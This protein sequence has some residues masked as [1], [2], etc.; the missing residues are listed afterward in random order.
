M[1]T[2]DVGMHNTQGKF[3]HVLEKMVIDV[4]DLSGVKSTKEFNLVDAGVTNLTYSG[5]AKTVDDKLQIPSH[6][7]QLPFGKLVLYIY[8]S[9]L[10]PALGYTSTGQMFQSW[11]N[12]TSVGQTIHDIFAKVPVVGALMTPTLGK[13]VCDAGLQAAGN[14]VETQIQNSISGATVFEL[15]SGSCEAG[16]PLGPKRLALKLVNGAWSGK[17]TEGAFTGPFT[18]TFTGERQ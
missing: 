16:L 8:K 17:I 11:I 7:F 3:T 9:Q 14:W 2:L 6:S 1:T 18:G 13:T 5:L 15:T 10:L 4:H 12:C